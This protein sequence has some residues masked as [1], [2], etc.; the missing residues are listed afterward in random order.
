MPRG[1]HGSQAGHASE[2]PQSWRSA[3]IRIDPNGTVPLTAITGLAGGERIYDAV[4]NWWS[5]RLPAQGG[6]CAGLFSD[7]IL[8]TDVA[9]GEAAGTTLYAQ[10]AAAVAAEFREGHQVLLRDSD[11]PYVDVT[12]KVTGVVEAG[13]NS[14]IQVVTLEADANAITSHNLTNVDRILIIGN[15]N[16]QGG[17]VPEAISYNPTLWT[18]YA[19]V[20]HTPLN[21][22]RTAIQ[23]K[24]RTGDLYTERK[25][26]TLL[27]HSLEIEKSLIWGK[28]TQNTGDNGEPEYTTDGLIPVIKTNVLA[29]VDAFHLNGDY[30]GSKWVE[31]GE[32]WLDNMLEGIFRYDKTDR[33]AFCGTGTLLALQRLAKEGAEIQITPKTTSYGLRIKEWIHPQG[34]LNLVIHP[35]FSHEPTDRR[36]MVIFNPARLHFKYIQDTIFYKDKDARAG[37][38]E[39][40]DGI[41]ESYL[42]E[43][44]LEYEDPIGF[45]YLTGFGLNNSV[46]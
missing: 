11:D 28:A 26:E 35:L 43:G 30:A 37:K 39:K 33:M 34:T 13:D 41:K 3:I 8:S 44:L 27:L 19:Q 32:E 25:M 45:G 1:M 15:V 21:L 24:Y 17:E 31:A 22:S 2:R 20:W 18:N 5:K 7:A 12:A 42:T 16:P 23:T 9:G 38:Y 46:E 36:S 6:A 4:H 14:Y 40:I 10:V 29:N